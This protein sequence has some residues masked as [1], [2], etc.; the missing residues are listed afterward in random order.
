[1]IRLESKFWYSVPQGF[2]TQRV[3]KHCAYSQRRHWLRPHLD[4]LAALLRLFVSAMTHTSSFCQNIL[5]KSLNI[6]KSCPKQLWCEESAAGLPQS[7]WQW[8]WRVCS[9]C[10]SGCEITVAICSDVTWSSS[11]GHPIHSV[12]F[13]P[14]TAAWTRQQPL[15]TLNNQQQTP[16]VVLLFLQNCR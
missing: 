16:T 1:M 10:S 5:L 3:E 14:T 13:W 15:T 2:Q 4:H 7:G 9:R 12:R 6:A 8:M 11:D